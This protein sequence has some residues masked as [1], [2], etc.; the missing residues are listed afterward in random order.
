MIAERVPTRNPQPSPDCPSTRSDAGCSFL[1]P[2][3]SGRTQWTSL[4]TDAEIRRT[5]PP[6]L[7]GFPA[8][9]WVNAAVVSPA[10]KQA[11]SLEVDRDVLRSYVA[12]MHERTN[13][14]GSA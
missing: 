8:G 2:H 9:F 7:V 3:P 12:A 11:I 4:A 14:R 5:S 10:P 1:R 13:S 6:E